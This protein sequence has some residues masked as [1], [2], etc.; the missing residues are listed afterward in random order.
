MIYHFLI[1]LL[2]STSLFGNIVEEGLRSIPCQ[3][4]EKMNH[5]F[6]YA[7]KICHAGYVLYFESKPVCLISFWQ[8]DDSTTK[9]RDGWNAYKKY[10]DLFPHRNYIFDECNTNI[11]SK[12]A[13]NIYL[14]NRRRFV[15]CINQYSNIFKEILHQ[16]V[17]GEKFLQEIDKGKHLIDLIEGNEILLGILLGYGEESSKLYHKKQ[18]EFKQN[19]MVDKSYVT[20]TSENVDE[21]EIY[22]V[23]FKGNIN[24]EEAKQISTKFHNERKLLWKIYLEKKQD[25][26]NFFLDALCR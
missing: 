18:L 20:I 14:I 8:E 7:I 3:E 13:V 19:Q 24:S 26:I 11:T 25:S 2:V 17:E 16:E 21:I 22:P 23:V 10:K 5:F 15:E 9:F 12:T 1:F 6:D 4:K